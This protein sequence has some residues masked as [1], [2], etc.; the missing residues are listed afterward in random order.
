M[1]ELVW[2]KN[3]F[4]FQAS[5]FDVVN[6]KCFYFKTRARCSNVSLLSHSAD[7]N[8]LLEGLDGVLEDGLDG[9]H[10]TES[11]LHIIDLGLHA[12]D[13][14][15]L[16]GNFNEGLSV[17][18]SLQDSCSEGFLDVL[19]GSSLGNSGIIDSM[20]F[21]IESWG[22]FDLELGKKSIICHSFVWFFSLNITIV[23]SV[24]VIG[25]YWDQGEGGNCEEFHFWF[26]I[27]FILY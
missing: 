21:W 9:L 3:L 26:L 1:K 25:W 4:P 20:G 27:I 5:F 15:H 2:T 18:E 7:I 12:F 17:I 22:E 19:N 14:L 24:V 11:S 6:E 10:D 16:S 8:D 13:G 23:W